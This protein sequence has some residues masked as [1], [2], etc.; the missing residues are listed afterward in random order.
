MKKI[1]LTSG[2]SFSVESNTSADDAKADVSF[3][4][5]PTVLSEK[6]GYELINRS[7]PSASNIY[8]YDQLMENLIRYEGKIG[9]VVA[10]WSYSFKTNLFGQQELN[11]INPEDQDNKSL[12][13]PVDA[14]R[15]TVDIAKS[16]EQSLR[17]ITYLQDYCDS[18]DILCVHYPLLN[19]FKTGLPK[20]QHIDVLEQISNSYFYKR[21]D[22]MNNVIGWPSD[23]ML[24]GYSYSV[25]YPNLVI[26]NLDHHPNK[27]G[28]INI[29]SEMYDKY[30]LLKE[31]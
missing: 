30:Q 6:L 18:K 10:G 28:H 7:A 17:L 13:R 23:K 19:L 12:I 14:L 3:K 2:S 15:S 8:I 29:A 16:I 31:T 21:L 5:W 26:S 4:R 9:L 20:D 25:A 11:F 1:L 27:Q 22:D 24:G